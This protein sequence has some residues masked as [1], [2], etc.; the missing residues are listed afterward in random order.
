MRGLVA[1]HS[2]DA[3]SV[4]LSI[5]ARN[6]TAAP[7]DIERALYDERSVVRMLGMRRTVFVVPADIAPVVQAASADDIAARERRRLVDLLEGA[8][9]AKDAKRWLSKVEAATLD[10]LAARGEATAA[11]LGEDV[12]AL[13]TQVAF[14][15]GKKWEGTV[16]VSTRLLFV[17]AAEGRILRGRPR[18]TWS[19]TQ[20]RWRPAPP[21][22]TSMAGTDA[23]A[24]L[25]ASWLRSFGPAPIADLQWWT[26]WTVAKTKR[27]VAALD[28][29]PVELDGGGTGVVLADDMAPTRKPRPAAALLPAL[30][31]TVMGWK[32]RSWFL[33]PA[34]AVALFDR[35]GNAGPTVWWDGRVVGGWAQRKDTGDVVWRLLEDVGKAAEKA[36]ASEAARIQQW[37]GDVRVAPRFRTPLERE[38]SA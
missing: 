5:A 9:I 25:A 13:R 36:I 3:C 6:T 7:A 10:A 31:P 38:L 37:L 24:R 29:E 35:S 1:L 34:H 28:T 12:P 15:E 16:G 21:G 8:G 2:T 27:A 22:D 32:E 18:G 19:S 17:L 33:D 4:F 20:Y 14:G 23:A 30:D 26:G 11:Q